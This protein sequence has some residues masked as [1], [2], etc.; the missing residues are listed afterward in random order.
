MDEVS[1]T[2][3]VEIMNERVSESPKSHQ[4]DFIVLPLTGEMVMNWFTKGDSK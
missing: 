4:G 2:R 1:F 3:M